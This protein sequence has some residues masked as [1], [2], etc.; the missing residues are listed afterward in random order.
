MN[1]FVNIG[2][3]VGKIDA[4]SLATGV[5]RFTSDF[6]IEDPL[7]IALLYS[8]HA[9][10]EIIDI[11]TSEAEQIDGVVD[12]LHYKN[13]PRVLHTTAG[14]GYPE[15][16]PYDTVLFDNMV[17]YVGDRVAL[18]AAETKE[19]AREAVGRIKVTYNLLEPVFDPER[20]REDDAPRIHGDDVY[21]PIPAVY[22]PEEN[23]AAELDITIGDIERGFEEADFIIEHVYKTH[24][25]SHCALEPHAAIAY[26][27]E[28]GRLVIVTTT[29]VP[30]HVRRIVSRL[31][32]MPE[33][34]IRVIKPRIG[35]GFGGKQEVLLEP[36]VALVATRNKRAAKLVLS[37]KEV[38]V[39]TR[40]RHPM[41]IRLKAGVKDDGTITALAMDGL[42]NSGAY[43]AHA[44]TVLSNVGAKV[45]PLFNKIENVSF[46]GRSVYTNL[47]VGGA[48]RGYGATQGYFAFCQ[49]IDIIARTLNQ[50]VLEFYKRWHIKEGETSEVFRAL[51]EGGEGVGQVIRSCKLSECIDRGAEAIGWYDKRGKKIR[52]G[53]ERVKGVGVAV[54][55][56][57]SGIPKI[58]MASA[59]MKMNEDGSFNLFVGA[60]DLGTGSDTILA[61]IA[62]EVLSV[63]VEQ[64]IVTSSDTDLTPFDTGAYASSTTYISGEAVRKCALKIKEQILSVG[65]KMLD[66][67][68]DK[69]VL[70]A[71][72]VLHIE[73][74]EQISFKEV[75]LQSLYRADQF[76][77][78]AHASHV[79]SESPPPFIAQ[80]AEVDVDVRTGRVT[81]VR[82][83]SAVDCGQPINPLLVEGQ[84][85]GAVVN[86]ISYALCED[87]L[88]DATGRLQNRNFWNYKIYTIRDIP[89][90]ETIV[91]ESYE[92]TGPF[93]AKSVGEVAINGP[94]PAI[95]NAVYDAVGVRLYE[96]PFTPE[97]VLEKIRGIG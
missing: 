55:M 64:I 23:V 2:R 31:I 9:H 50:D 14:Q 26:F 80:F 24:Y 92:E 43:G 34:M 76:Q 3:S 66:G 95:A 12:I 89:A 38:F 87:Y 63:P 86:G 19:S 91:L 68:R 85:E 67:D 82:F 62:S 21:T 69:L 8:P 57:G 20:A 75:C 13:V 90:I 60:T 52:V 15:P 47:P 58:D 93:G 40:T 94:L 71:G 53:K 44:L 65:S 27:D 56:Q 16:S 7:C 83:V 41:R 59:S 39:S 10:A 46:T 72:N 51:G 33:G 35:G 97:K 18:V 88:F 30:F 5:E 49:H 61:Q 6:I 74:K 70:D 29:Q 79:A 45:L 73:T 54:A 42:K 96:T 28:R 36:L 48:Y 78:Q 37:R 81:V 17:R 1:D 11:D 4:L 25:A 22:R 32:S 84:V 77:I